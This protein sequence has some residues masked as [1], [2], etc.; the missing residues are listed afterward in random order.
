MVGVGHVIK[1]HA[2]L[3]AEG[4]LVA[5]SRGFL[6]DPGGGVELAIGLLG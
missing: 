2:V 5:W 4:K 1:P 6:K 3:V